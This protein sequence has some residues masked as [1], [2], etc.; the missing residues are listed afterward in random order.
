[1]RDYHKV[2]L[3]ESTLHYSSLSFFRKKKFKPL[4]GRF[5]EKTLI[6]IQA[7]AKSTLESLSYMLPKGDLSS[8]YRCL[9]ERKRKQVSSFFVMFIH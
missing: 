9:S 7:S 4:M 6:T 1:M 2:E 8:L 5:I 3:M